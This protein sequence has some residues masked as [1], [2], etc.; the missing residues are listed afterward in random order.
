VGV[1][2]RQWS[3]CREEAAEEELWRGERRGAW[4]CAKTG[5][6]RLGDGVMHDLMHDHTR[7]SAL[8]VEAVSTPPSPLP[9]LRPSWRA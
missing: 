7:P 8:L 1:E 6:E 2:R 5:W 4:C 3:G 9:A